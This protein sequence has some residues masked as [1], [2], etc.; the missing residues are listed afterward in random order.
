MKNADACAV[1]TGGR[2]GLA[3]QAGALS[4]ASRQARGI[5]ALVQTIFEVP[6]LNGETIRLGGAIRMQPK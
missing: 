3:G 5:P 4:F 6:Y 2:A 1:V